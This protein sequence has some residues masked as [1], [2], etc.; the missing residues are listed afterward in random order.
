MFH[1]NVS[2]YL[3]IIADNPTPAETKHRIIIPN[4]QQTWQ[5][6]K[7]ASNVSLMLRSPGL[8]QLC[9]SHIYSPQQLSKSGTLNGFSGP[10]LQSSFI[11]LPKP[12]AATYVTAVLHK[13][14]NNFCLSRDFYCLKWNIMT[15]SNLKKKGFSNNP[16]SSQ[17]TVYH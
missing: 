17:F 2:G 6:L 1:F 3:L 11:I 14:R 8:H 9:S 5:S 15:K 10:K 7:E 12:T 4:V 13:A 16:H